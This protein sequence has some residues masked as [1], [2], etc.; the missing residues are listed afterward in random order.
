[1]NKSIQLETF[2]YFYNVL[3]WDKICNQF[4]C[5]AK[6]RDGMQGFKPQNGRGSKP[7]DKRDSNQGMTGV[8][9]Q[10]MARVQN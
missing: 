8:Q 6:S 9:N 3:M 1:M 10:E 5:S 2:Y 4:F 7:W